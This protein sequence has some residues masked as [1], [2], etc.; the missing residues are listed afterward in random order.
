MKTIKIGTRGSKL[1]LWQ[2]NHI[3]DLLI[4]NNPEIDF[5]LVIIK[6]KGDK[7]LDT[8]LSKIGDKGL[9]TKELENALISKEI[10]LAVHSMKDVP[11]KLIEGSFISTIITREESNDA[12]ISNKYNSFS[13]LPNGAIVG[14]SSLRRKAQLLIKRP[15]LTFIDIRGNVD[16]RL[17]KLDN[18][19]YDAIILA[20]AG[21]YRL[22]WNSRIKEKIDFNTCL[23]AVGQGAI[24]LQIRENDGFIFKIVD[25]I[26]DI[27][28]SFCVNIERA[29][30]STLEGGCQIPIACQ[31]YFNDDGLLI[32]GKVTSID[33]VENVNKFITNKLTLEEVS[34]L[35]YKTSIREANF[36]GNSLATNLI[37]LGA[38]RI[39][40]N[41]R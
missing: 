17:A 9:F 12:F 30:L 27:K 37:E 15:D 6:T 21:L 24:G 31:A 38:L 22:G 19:E 35:D 23:P 10:D 26:N 14:T 7:V 2:A 39:I 18:A 28:T 29:F 20:Y 33:G 40:T 5:E 34:K 11:T 4:K 13:E 36:I 41:I 3:K 25:K 32:E 1:A 16:T 8:A